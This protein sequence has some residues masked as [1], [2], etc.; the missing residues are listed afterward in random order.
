MPEAMQAKKAV[1]TWEEVIAPNPHEEVRLL[2][3]SVREECAWYSGDPLRHPPIPP[4]P[5]VTVNGHVKNNSQT[6]SWDSHCAH[7]QAEDEKAGYLEQ[8]GEDG[9]NSTT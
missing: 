9:S 7:H 2:P 3:N 8:V 4:H 5:V 6:R 1:A